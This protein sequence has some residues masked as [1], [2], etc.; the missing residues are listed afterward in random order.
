MIA[1]VTWLEVS[2]GI[3]HGD[4][5]GLADLAVLLDQDLEDLA[6]DAVVAAVDGDDADVGRPLAEPVDA[7]LALLVPGGVPG[8]VVVDDGVEVVLQVDALGQA[9]GGDQDAAGA[10]V[11]ARLPRRARSM[12]SMRWAGESVPLTQATTVLRPSL[13]SRCSATYSLVGM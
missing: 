11:L 1:S 5:G 3:G 10:V 6:V 9:V 7:A 2:S 12:R 13:P 8:E 4:A